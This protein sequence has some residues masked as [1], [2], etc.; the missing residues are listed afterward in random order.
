MPRT[1]S[2]TRRSTSRKSPASSGQVDLRDATQ[3][4]IER[5]A[6]SR[7]S[8]GPR[9]LA[10]GERRAPPRSPR[11]TARII[12]KTTSGGSWRSASMITTA[13]PG[14]EVEPGRDRQLV[15]EVPGQEQELHPWRR[16]ARSSSI[17]SRLRSVLPS[18][19][20]TNSQSPSSSSADRAQPSMELREDG[21]L[22]EH[23]DHERVGHLRFHST[24]L[25]PRCSSI[26]SKPRCRNTSATCGYTC[27]VI[28][29]GPRSVFEDLVP[30]LIL[31][32]VDRAVDLAR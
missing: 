14:G 23:R 9:R 30:A 17:V 6:P 5:D 29:F 3:Q 24:M 25:E 12:F 13:S 10:A 26:G 20:K 4:P 31:E 8:G 1:T 15:A 18:S 27:L 22:V 16:A 28:R 32:E 7:A 11:A 2:A 21:L 19:T